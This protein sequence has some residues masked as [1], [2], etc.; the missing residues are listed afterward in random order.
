M[1]GSTS[2]G[3]SPL[4][5]AVPFAC[6]DADSNIRASKHHIRNKPTER[7]FSKFFR[8][9]GC[10]LDL[11]WE[12]EIRN[13]EP[14]LLSTETRLARTECI[15]VDI[16][17]WCYAFIAKGGS[18]QKTKGSRYAIANVMNKSHEKTIFL[19]QTCLDRCGCQ[20]RL[21]KRNYSGNNLND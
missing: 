21:Y 10:H 4:L 3:R 6:P 19:P 14:S 9:V 7:H 12:T 15:C 16:A 5:H 11:E 17:P 18:P 20:D 13:D 2:P 1:E 8:M